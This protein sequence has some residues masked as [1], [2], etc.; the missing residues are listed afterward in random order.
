MEDMFTICPKFHLSFYYLVDMGQKYAS[1][2]SGVY[3]KFFCR[4]LLG[5]GVGP[6]LVESI[7]QYF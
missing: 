2:K 5:G 3:Q 1:P 7:F 6:F 4:L